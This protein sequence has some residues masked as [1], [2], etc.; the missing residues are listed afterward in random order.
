MSTIVTS[1]VNDV[2]DHRYTLSDNGRVMFILVLNLHD[3][4]QQIQSIINV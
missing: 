1:I 2:N 3:N 4:I